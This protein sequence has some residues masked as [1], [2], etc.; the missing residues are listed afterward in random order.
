M[1][2][3]TLAAEET[4]QTGF[5]HVISV[6]HTDLTDTAATTKTL[7]L[8]TGLDAGHIVT[9][10]A[11]RLQTPFDGGATN[12]LVLDVG[13]DLAADSSGRDRDLRW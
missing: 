4:R 1:N 10:A 5:T 11:F 13:Y 9:G 3:Q 7:N 12:A 8:I 6:Y 2:V